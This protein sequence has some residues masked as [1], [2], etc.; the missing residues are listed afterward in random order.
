MRASHG[1][2]AEV[3]AAQAARDV[4][5][6]VLPAQQAIF[7]AALEAQLAVVPPGL[8]RQGQEVGRQAALAVLEWRQGDGWPA[9]IT[10]DP[11]YVLP[12]FPGQ[13]Q[14]TP[15]ANSAP[16]F[17]FYSGV[18]P[19]GLLTSTQ[20]L[21]AAPPT[22]TSARYAQDLNETKRLGSA[23]SLD[24]TPEET[25]TAQIIAGVGSA[26]S[27][28]HLWSI[29]AATVA[30]SHGLP[31]LETARLFALTSVSQH[32][33]LQTSF[34]SK[35]VYGLWRP[36]TAIR[37]ANEDLNPDTTAE[38]GWTPLLTTPPYPSHAGNVACLSAA[39]A[40]ALALFFGH[41]DVPFSVTWTRAVPPNV[42]RDYAGFWQLADQAAR[43]RILGGI[44]FQFESDASQAACSKVAEFVVATYMR[45][46][47]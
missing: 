5:T 1:A 44:H 38:P 31:L 43:S 42:T 30:E 10:P 27:I 16:T 33:G 12:P 23:G 3:A 8:A 25:T 7:D 6:A 35:F 4:L 15:P 28:T 46:R 9:S 22:L 21:P 37:R 26:P 45:P 2:S 47:R 18:K 24:R 40:R 29:V 13:W 39:H 14:P 41:D 11:T 34:T 20:F 36:V 32:D 17:R 19:F